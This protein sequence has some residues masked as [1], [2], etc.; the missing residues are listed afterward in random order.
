MLREE[1]EN[2][3]QLAGPLPPASVK[4]F[5]SSGFT[6][7]HR[8]P[9]SPG[10]GLGVVCRANASFRRAPSGTTVVPAFPYL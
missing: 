10:E 6:A 9:I 7:S 4:T 3:K 2:L 1:V 8:W 5:P